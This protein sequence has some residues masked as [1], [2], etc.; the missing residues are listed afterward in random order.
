MWF[1][2]CSC[3]HVALQLVDVT[4]Y[5]TCA[6]TKLIEAKSSN[7]SSPYHSCSDT[8]RSRSQSS[9]T[10]SCAL[11]Q[12]AAK[13]MA[14]L[15]CLSSS[16]LRPATIGVLHSLHTGP[17]ITFVAMTVAA[18]VAPACKRTTASPKNLSKTTPT[19]RKCGLF[20]M[21]CELCNHRTFRMNEELKMILDNATEAL[22]VT[23]SEE[24]FNP[25]PSK[26]VC[27]H[28]PFLPLLMVPCR[29]FDRKSKASRSRR[30]EHARDPL[31]PQRMRACLW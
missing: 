29:I 5:R 16:I 28:H 27:H 9:A 22:G 10:S 25:S 31:P 15:T 20:D 18:L 24:V 6:M 2:L 12:A 23:L 8:D 1:G 13:D 4:L 21:F 17:D 7:V 14:M 3:S 11:V 26:R 30:P 19:R